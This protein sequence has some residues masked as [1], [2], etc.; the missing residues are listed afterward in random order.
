[1]VSVQVVSLYVYVA[2]GVGAQADLDAVLEAVV[3]AV[4]VVGVGAQGDLE[5]VAEAVAVEVV[6]VDAALVGVEGVG[7]GVDLHA[8]VR[9][10]VFLALF[11][12]LFASKPAPISQTARRVL[13]SWVFAVP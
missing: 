13:E 7:A 5:V 9:A 12:A 8:V 6:G 10:V 2:G 3:V 4:V 1:M 11:P